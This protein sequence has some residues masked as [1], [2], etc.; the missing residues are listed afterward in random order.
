MRLLVTC[1]CG[2]QVTV[3]DD[4]ACSYGQCPA[5]GEQLLFPIEV[6]DID[7]GEPSV[8]TAGDAARPAALDPTFAPESQR[9]DVVP[10]AKDRGAA[11]FVYGVWGL[12]LAFALGLVAHFGH[13]V[14]FNDDFAI[15]PWWAGE[16]PITLAWL[17]APHNEHRIGLPKLVL[18]TLARISGGDF[19]AGMY[20]N[21]LA[22]GGL[23]L[24]LIGAAK[25]LRGGL[26]FTDAV[27]PLACLHWG[28]YGNFL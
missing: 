4:H 28:N 23:A 18:V 9:S 20:F 26:K 21:V 27:L 12:A 3:G 14:P 25:K 11:L 15:I 8:L 10:A 24:A 7:P 6:V 13:N 22:M 16:R 17:W 2:Q 1:P 19:R 5:C